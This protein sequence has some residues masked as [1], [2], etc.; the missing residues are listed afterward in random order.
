[1]PSALM[2]RRF[3]HDATEAAKSVVIGSCLVS[4]VFPIRRSY[5]YQPRCCLPPKVQARSLRSVTF[6]VA[7]AANAEVAAVDVVLTAD[8]FLTGRGDCA[9]TATASAV[10]MTPIWSFKI[11]ILNTVFSDARRGV[12]VRG[13]E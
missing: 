11:F 13:R 3:C 8:V 5:R 7:A 12:T 1:M 9:L 4:R 2:P 10:T 6:V